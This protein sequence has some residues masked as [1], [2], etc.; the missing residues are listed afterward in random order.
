MTPCVRA[1][2]ILLAV[3]LVGAGPALAGCSVTDPEPVPDPG[4]PARVSGIY[5]VECVPGNL[6][7][8]PAHLPT[9]C[10][11]ANESLDELVWQDWGEDVATA[12]GAL[13]ANDCDPTCV[14]GTV[15]RHRVE[16]TLDRLQHG[17]AL[18]VY[19]RLVVTPTDDPPAGWDG[20]QTFRLP[21]IEG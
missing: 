3:L 18:G 6:V 10:A 16:V 1:P 8:A 12:T 20:P 2:A 17:E 21:G 7:Q 19:R 11:D 9:A 14:D 13:V 5:V 15:S 4:V